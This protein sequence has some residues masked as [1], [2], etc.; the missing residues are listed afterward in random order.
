M[1]LIK[2]KKIAIIG[3]GPGGLTLARLLQ[4]GGADVKIYERDANKNARAQGATLDLHQES[5]LKALQVAGLM[6]EFKANYRPGA[7]KN[8]IMDKNAAIVLEDKPRAEDEIHR[9]EID[10]GPLQ[11]ILLNS[12]QPGTVI[13]GSH[14]DSLAPQND[15]WILKFKD[16]IS[17]PADIVIAA[18]GANSKVRPYITPIK[19][20]YSGI[21]VVEGSVY[22]SETMSP[23]M[24]QLLDGG[25]IF[26][27]GD[28]QSL[29]I[30]SKGDGSLVFY[31]GCKTS[32]NWARESGIDF[33]NKAEVLTWFKNQYPGW[34][35]VYLEL[36]ENVVTPFVVRPLYYMPLDQTWEALPN[37]T[38][39]GDAA[40][41]MTPFA[42]EGVNMAMQ[43]A[44]ELSKCLTGDD[45]AD[46]QTAIAA[47]EQQMRIRA[48]AAAKDSLESGELLHS[49]A[50]IP[51]MSNVV[52]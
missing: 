41:L 47:Y 26:S 6:D 50:A 42:G 30:S 18:D 5:G 35:D 28:D 43:D 33:G 10:R 27:F 45:F 4:I 23:K 36:F 8:R 24:H 48:S 13:W 16:G 11:H 46:L 21:T 34:N 22:D 44:L 32:E 3:G 38:M 12:L 52:G 7:E 49:P 37:I 51:F 2:N 40:H 20:I 19:S 14:F 39:L 15:S 29:I 9:P 31:T 17:V 1:N 25:K